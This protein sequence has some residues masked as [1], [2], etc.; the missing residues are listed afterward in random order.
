M[1]DCSATLSEVKPRKSHIFLWFLENQKF[2]R[3]PETRLH[4]NVNVCLVDVSI[5]SFLLICL[6]TNF[7]FHYIQMLIELALTHTGPHHKWPTN[8]SS[9]FLVFCLYL[10]VTWDCYSVLMMQFCMFFKNHVELPFGPHNCERKASPVSFYSPLIIFS[11]EREQRGCVNYFSI[12]STSWPL[13][14]V[15]TAYF[16]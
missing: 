3:W 13:S 10:I 15:Y 5:G 12:L 1:L 7:N 11:F 4:M 14:W 9:V 2:I 16:S 8:A 6:Q